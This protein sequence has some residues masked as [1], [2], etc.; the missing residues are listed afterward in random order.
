MAARDDV[1]AELASGVE[2]GALLIQLL[3]GDIQATHHIFT[4]RYQLWY[5][6]ALRLLAVLAPDRAAEFRSYYEADPKRKSFGSDTYTIQDYVRG[7]G[8]G[9]NPR[10][11]QPLWD[12]LNVVRI[13]MFAQRA[14][15]ASLSARIDGVLADIEASLA[16]ELEDA[17]LE[18]ARRLAQV[19]LRAAGALAGVV[20]EEHLQQ[21]ARGRNVATSKSHPTIADLNDS[22]KQS[23]VYDV[24][25]WRRLQLLADIR[26]LCTHKKDSDP[27][28]DQLLDLIAG[29]DWAVKTIR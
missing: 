14:I 6:R 11:T 29:V 19:N 16:A 2:E 7:L 8:P 5:T 22:L 15:L 27:T 26:N 13:C 25:T 24:P 17:T 18:T 10:T 20:L 23:G 28:K 12:A 4:P 21:V 3:E 1:K 9:T